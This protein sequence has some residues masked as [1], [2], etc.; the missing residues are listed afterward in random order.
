MYEEEKPIRQLKYAVCGRLSIHG[1][2]VDGQVDRAMRSSIV[3]PVGGT[4]W[5]QVWA[6]VKRQ[7]KEVTD[8]K[9]RTH[10]G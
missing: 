8:E 3:D 4:A 2:P 7:V 1:Y 5:A 9:R 6:V 10:S